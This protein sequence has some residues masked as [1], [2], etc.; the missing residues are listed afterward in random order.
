MCNQIINHRPEDR[1]SLPEINVF[2]RFLWNFVKYR[3]F[4]NTL[5]YQMQSSPRRIILFSDLIITLTRKYS[6]K[7]EQP[8]LYIK[9]WKIMNHTAASKRVE[10]FAPHCCPTLGQDACSWIF[11]LMIFWNFQFFSFF[12]FFLIFLFF[13]CNFSFD[14]ITY[15]IEFERNNMKKHIDIL[16]LRAFPPVTR[17]TVHWRR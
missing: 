14:F 15:N 5:K 16:T 2:G 17:L 10:C 7:I 1:G 12:R 11:I 6:S 4:Q 13:S 9:I 3:N 8:H